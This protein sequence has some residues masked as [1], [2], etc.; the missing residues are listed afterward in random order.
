[1]KLLN[2]TINNPKQRLSS[3]MSEGSVNDHK[4]S[5]SFDDIIKYHRRGRD[6]HSKAIFWG[7]RMINKGFIQLVIGLVKKYKN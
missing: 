2:E 5:P 3:S 6:L 4:E 1:M 7:F